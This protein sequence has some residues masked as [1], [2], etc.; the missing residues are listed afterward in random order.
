MLAQ[1][2]IANNSPQGSTVPKPDFFI[3]LCELVNQK[4]PAHALFVTENVGRE[5][6]YWRELYRWIELEEMYDHVIGEFSPA[7]ITRLDYRAIRKFQAQLKQNYTDDIALLA[8]SCGDLQPVATQA[9]EIA[10]SVGLSVNTGKTKLFS[11]C[12]PDY[13]KAPLWINGCRLEEVDRLNTSRRECCRM[14]RVKTALFPESTLIGGFSRSF[15]SG[16]DV[17]SVATKIRRN[18]ASVRSALLYGCACWVGRVGDEERLEVFDHRCLRAILQ[19]KHKDYVLNE[20]KPFNEHIAA[21][22]AENTTSC[23]IMTGVMPLLP[24]DMLIL[25]RISKTM[26]PVGVVEVP[27]PLRLVILSLTPKKSNYLKILETAHTFGVFLND[28]DF[29]LTCEAATSPDDL[30][31]A[32]DMYLSK[33]VVMPRQ[34]RTVLPFPT[35]VPHK[36]IALIL[37]EAN[38]APKKTPEDYIELLEHEEPAKVEHFTAKRCLHTVW[39]P[40]RDLVQGSCA[41]AHRFA[42]DFADAFTKP[43]V[44]LVFGSIFLVY[45]V[46]FGPAITFGTLMSTQIHPSF[47]VSNSILTSGVIT[48]M[49]A[50]FAGQ[51]IAIIGPSGPS[52]IMEALIAQV[53][54]KRFFENE[55]GKLG[56]ELYDYR[57]W[58]CIYSVIFGIFL[59]A[60]NLSE[61]ATTTTKSLEELYSACIAGFLIIKALFSVFK[62]IPQ[63][64]PTGPGPINGTDLAV[65]RSASTMGVT[66]FLALTMAVF[67]ITVAKIKQSRMFRRKIRFWV[68]SLTVPLGIIF[69]T[70]LERIFFSAFEIPT[71][72]VPPFKEINYSTWYRLP[73]F[74]SILFKG[75]S[76]SYL[77]HLYA[78]LYGFVLG[79][80]IFVEV[81]FNSHRHAR[82]GLLT[83][84]VEK[85]PVSS[86]GDADHKVSIMVDIHQ[87]S[88]E[89][90]TEEVG[91]QY[92]V[93][94]HS[95]GQPN[96]CMTLH[97]PLRFTE[98]LAA[99]EFAL[100]SPS[101][102]WRGGRCEYKVSVIPGVEAD[103]SPETITWFCLLVVT[104]ARGVATGRNAAARNHSV[105][106][107][108][109]KNLETFAYLE[110]T[111]SRNTRIDDEVAQRISKASQAFDRLQT[112]VWNR[113]GIYLNTKLKMYKAVVL[114]TLLYGAETWTVYPNQA[115]KLNHFHLSCL[116]EILKLR[117]Q[118]RIPETGVLERTGILSIHAILMQ[119]QMR[120]SSHL[121]RMDDERVTE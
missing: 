101:D 89:H 31:D 23:C 107:A 84:T 85:V 39:P 1:A 110:N 49:N 20:R 68:G 93:L 50:L 38:T 7:E 3:E 25:A 11:S 35:V 48:I 90:E 80:I 78:A 98:S 116:R 16:P 83:P 119:V 65:L 42:S 9:N 62:P 115:R 99:Y 32:I 97:S 15:E 70:A 26:D 19:M 88:R 100:A 63:S 66:A 76:A 44:G 118:D 8:S 58:V 4:V 22:C 77:I 37:S 36:E 59:L 81:S 5:K 34:S 17:T 96:V 27:Y 14:D 12:N 41:L 10:I 114:T 117:W 30:L 75:N 103:T 108:Q 13:E 105:K 112:S 61:V 86:V 53:K 47:S 91:G 109:L 6:M 71:L 29:Q 18:R 46:I 87:H 33:T 121:V 64:L 106:C 74:N 120:W 56:V 2:A 82:S 69:V 73:D 67:C 40:M 51:P 92:A 102:F 79:V 104:V 60:L 45:F 113:Y 43:N 52:F 21:C 55:A 94:H 28:K 111:L 95:I 72:Q 57:F 54:G 24:Y